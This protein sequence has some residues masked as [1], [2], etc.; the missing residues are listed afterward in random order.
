MEFFLL[1][2]GYQTTL[3]LRTK[4]RALEDDKKNKA[5]SNYKDKAWHLAE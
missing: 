1:R 3:T 5:I 4:L 2:D